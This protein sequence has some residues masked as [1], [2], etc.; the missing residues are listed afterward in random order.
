MEKSPLPPQKNQILLLRV[1]ANHP[2]YRAEIAILCLRM[3]YN[4]LTHTHVISHLFPLSYHFWKINVSI[5]IDHL[6]TCSALS[7]RRNSH[8]VP[9]PQTSL[10]NNHEALFCTLPY[11]HSIGILH[12]T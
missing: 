7:S 12:L 3:G 6:F 11:L 10:Q 9:Q 4:R 2:S 1:T 8:L 5:S